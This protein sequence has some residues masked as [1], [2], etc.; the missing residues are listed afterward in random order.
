[1]EKGN[2]RSQKS[3]VQDK[4]LGTN[5]IGD[6]SSESAML[7]YDLGTS[8]PDAFAS[9][10]KDV[11]ESVWAMNQ[12]A[13]T[14]AMSSFYSDCSG[15]LVRSAKRL[16]WMHRTSIPYHS[17]TNGRI[18]REI[19]HVEEGTRTLL[20]RAGLDPH[21]WPLAARAFC[22]AQNISCR[23]ERSSAWEQRFND[24]PFSGPRIPFGAAC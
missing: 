10:N 19:R 3:D 14:D 18:E 13:G 15:E 16:G 20:M 11:E 8:W 24:G 6:E 23:G 17:K 5:I 9:A 4:P 7:L 21:W 1:M 12:F 22:L 2:F